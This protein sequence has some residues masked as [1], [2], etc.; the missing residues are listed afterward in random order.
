MTNL[1]LFLAATIGLTNIVLLG[2]FPLVASSREWVM[3]NGPPRIKEMWSCPMCMGF[4]CGLFLG[5]LTFPLGWL[6]FPL[7]F[8]GS[9]ACRL[10]SFIETY[11]EANSMVDMGGSDA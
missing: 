10:S 1:L 3:K 9:F 8:A 5:L 4:W 11:L 6:T 2:N 7:A